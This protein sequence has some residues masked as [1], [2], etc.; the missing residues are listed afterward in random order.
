MIVF[1]DLIGDVLSNKKL[2]P[3][4]TKLF[5]RGRKLSIFLVFIT[6]SCFAVP[7]NIRQ[8]STHYFPMKI[9]NKRELQQIAFN[10]SSDI[11]FQNFSNF[12]KKCT[13]K[14]CYFLD[15]SCIK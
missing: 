5:I 6:Q 4:V 7:K 2:N 15:Y 12:H 3:I 8:N 1:D 10:H 9:P 11:D 13:A 14:P